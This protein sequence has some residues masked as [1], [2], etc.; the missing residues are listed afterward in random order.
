MVLGPWLLIQGKRVRAKTPKLPEPQ[1][2]ATGLVGSGLGISLLLMGDSSAAGV[3]AETA[4]ESLL[5][6]LLQ[7]LSTTHRID[8]TMLARTGKTTADMLAELRHT[9]A[10][11]FDVVL[12]ALGVNDVTSQV[13]FAQWKQQQLQL[14]D[15]IKEKFG[16]RQTIMSGL[17]PVRDFPA[18]PWPLSAYLGSYADVM[19][20][21]L[22]EISQ[23]QPLVEFHSLRGYPETAQAASDG[24][25]PGPEVYKLWA[26]YLADMIDKP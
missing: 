16:P 13:P 10:R 9:Q 19:D 23:A 4:T 15:L 20:Q 6:Q 18:L 1:M 12:T 8:Y 14:I 24:F 25:H 7:Q 3:G 5:G 21:A 22:I 26:E 2:P 17:P 11:K